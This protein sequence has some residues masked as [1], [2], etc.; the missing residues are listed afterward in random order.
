M[1][2]VSFLKAMIWVGFISLNTLIFK[3]WFEV[4]LIPFIAPFLIGTPAMQLFSSVTGVG[5]SVFI[6]VAWWLKFRKG[7]SSE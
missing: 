2:K 4:S 5:W 1:S 7:G 6:F 3:T